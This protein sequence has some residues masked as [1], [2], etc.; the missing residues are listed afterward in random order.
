MASFE[1]VELASTVIRSLIR[2]GN[3]FNEHML[4]KN[5]R[6][7][8]I[9]SYPCWVAKVRSLERRKTRGRQFYRDVPIAT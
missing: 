4:N 1:A 2:P 9:Q 5:A 8:S 7:K 3:S 6:V